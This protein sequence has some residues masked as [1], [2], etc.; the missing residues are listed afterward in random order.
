[1]D[2]QTHTAQ[3]LRMSYAWH[4]SAKMGHIFFSGA[5]LH[6]VANCNDNPNRN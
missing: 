3:N 4:R 6:T 5:L 1:M 2:R